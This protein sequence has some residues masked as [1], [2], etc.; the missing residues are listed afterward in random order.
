MRKA[1]PMKSIVVTVALVVVVMLAGC[2]R[3]SVTST[4][5]PTATTPPSTS[6]APLPAQITDALGNQVTVTD[7][8]RI[9]VING[10]VTE[11]VF[12][13]GLGENVVAVDTS[14]THPAEVTNLPQVGY[15]RRLS[16]E[17]VLSMDPTVVIGNTNAGPPE[18]IEQIRATGV[19]VVI[20]ESVTT[21]DGGGRGRSAGS[22]KRWESPLEERRSQQNSKPRLAKSGRFRLRRRNGQRPY[23]F[24]CAGWTRSSWAERGT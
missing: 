13:L 17:G 1:L 7:I 10:D 21:V 11:V 3:E 6:T 4:P 16:A 14:A 2:S 9:V 8:S 24:T 12:A 22:H 18:V 20:L 19:P 23:S 5:R 15:Q